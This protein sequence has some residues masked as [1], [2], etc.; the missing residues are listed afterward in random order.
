MVRHIH[1][2]RDYW[3]LPGG[4]IEEGETAEEA[5]EREVLEET[6]IRVQVERLLYTTASKS[7]RNSTHCFLMTA[8]EH[9]GIELG[10]D[11]EEA[12]LSQANRMLQDVKWHSVESVRDDIMVSRIL[13]LLASE[14][15]V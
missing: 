4:G 14:G 3:T 8:P 13:E 12:H 7:G 9:D 2:G 10:I 15:G 6:G 1:D 11:P 5:A